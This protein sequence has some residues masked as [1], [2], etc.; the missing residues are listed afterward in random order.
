MIFSMMN[1]KES[2]FEID[3]DA[4]SVSYMPN[5]WSSVTGYGGFSADLMLGGD[6]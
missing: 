5:T 4:A 2:L 6:V 3:A 1:W